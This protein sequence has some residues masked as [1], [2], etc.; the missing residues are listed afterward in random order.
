MKTQSGTFALKLVILAANAVTSIVLFSACKKS[1]ILPT[2]ERPI[3]IIFDAAGVKT[4]KTPD[5]VQKACRDLNNSGKGLCEI[6]F[7]NAK[8]DKLF[9]ESTRSLTMT[10]AV[11]SE[12]AANPASADP[13]HLMQK[14]TVDTLDTATDFLGQIK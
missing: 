8:G 13:V 2:N 9:H 1:L 7:Y 6:D 14:A 10:R 3:L 11:R 4:T 12:A 5:E